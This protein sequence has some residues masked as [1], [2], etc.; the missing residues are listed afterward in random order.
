[1]AKHLPLNLVP[2]LLLF[3]FGCASQQG[4]TQFP[5]PSELQQIA[6]PAQA[7]WLVLAER[8]DV[9]E[10]TLEEPVPEGDAQSPATS[11]SPFDRELEIAALTNMPPLARTQAMACAARELGRFYLQHGGSPVEGLQWYILSVCGSVASRIRTAFLYGTVPESVP[12]ERLAEQWRPQ[13]RPLISSA[14]KGGRYDRVGLW[15]GRGNGQA[16]VIVVVGESRAEF[17]TLS[18]VPDAKGR[19]KIEGRLKK[20]AQ[21]VRALVN[22]GRFGVEE[23]DLDSSVE[24]PRFA[25]SCPVDRSDP[26]TCISISAFPPGRVLGDRILYHV[27]W[28]AGVRTRR[29]VRPPRPTS[30]KVTSAEQMPEVIL[31]AV[32]DVRREAK[33][34]EVR[35]ERDQSKTAGRLAPI[36]L[37]AITGQ[38]PPETADKVALGMMAGWDVSGVVRQGRVSGAFT[39]QTQ[40]VG[41][42]LGA[43]LEEPGGRY[44]LL[45]PKAR[46]IAIGPVLHKEGDETLLGALVG[47]YSFFDANEDH[48]AATKAAYEKLVE[49]AKRHGVKG[50]TY[51]GDLARVAEESAAAVQKG[52]WSPEHALRNALGAAAGLNPGLQVTGMCLEVSELDQLEFQE[53][54][55]ESGSMQ[56]GMAVT[57]YKPSDWPWGRYVVLV[58]ATF[59][60]PMLTAEAQPDLTDR[61]SRGGAL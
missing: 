49:S 6:A 56:V 38:E 59:E 53:E 3:A 9:P 57:H 7:R 10:W 50:V 60:G 27:V 22:H 46:A 14:L 39:S 42:L 4:S 19:V 29:Y 37:L 31:R 40:D 2:V 41:D 18:R 8:R 32:N 33:M 35:F 52:D 58:L 25:I 20:D 11:S 13:V 12:M 44:T 21:M 51:S 24:L 1:M 30:M 28:P 43:A 17:S 54:F 23:C 16:V 47:T 61:L 15:F 34:P 48:A 55:F 45:D 36:Y 26:E 5:T